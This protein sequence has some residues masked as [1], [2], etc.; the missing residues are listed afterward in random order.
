MLEALSTSGLD[1]ASWPPRNMLSRN[2]PERVAA[3]AKQMKAKPRKVKALKV[4]Q[5][6]LVRK[7]LKV[8]KKTEF[9]L[10]HVSYAF[11]GRSYFQHKSTCFP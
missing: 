9:I 5:T 8:K 4:K 7:A 1:L 10:L 3:A 11:Y 2:V 6:T